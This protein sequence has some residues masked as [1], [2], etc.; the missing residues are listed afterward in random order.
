MNKETLYQEWIDRRKKV[1]ISDGFTDAIM[2]KI[3]TEGINQPRPLV[4]IGWLSLRYVK[5]ALIA[6]GLV[7]GLIRIGG[8][9][10]LVL[11]SCIEAKGGVI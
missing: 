5:A 8:I 7:G 9:I 3:R 10:G 11:G 2:A 4:K 6:A 1:E